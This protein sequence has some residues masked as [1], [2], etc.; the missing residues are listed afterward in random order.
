MLYTL[1]SLKQKDIH[2]YVIRF[3]QMLQKLLWSVN[4]I[5]AHASFMDT[6]KSRSIY[7]DKKGTLWN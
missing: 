1:A 2:V 6:K 3:F 7:L 5:F 4:H